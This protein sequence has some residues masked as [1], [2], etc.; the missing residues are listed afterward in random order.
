MKKLWVIAVLMIG[1]LL[2]G[3]G[4]VDNYPQRV[5]RYKNESNYNS[6]QFVDDFDFFW[7]ADR[8]LELTEWPV[9]EAD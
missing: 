3:C 9:R 7:L 8:P 2:V 4:M 1:G 6:R 5:N